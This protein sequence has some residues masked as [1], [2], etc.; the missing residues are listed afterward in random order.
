MKKY[1]E[2]EIEII[3]YCLS[4]VISVSRGSEAGNE[5]SYND[6]QGTEETTFADFEIPTDDNFW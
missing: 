5:L 4:D 3:E 2:P 6:E 1:V